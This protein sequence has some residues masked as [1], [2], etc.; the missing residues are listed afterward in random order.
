MFKYIKKYGFL[1][2]TGIILIQCNSIESDEIVVAEVNDKKLYASDLAEIIPNDITN[3]DS[4]L[5]A[6]DYIKKWVKQE[7]VIQKANENL[8]LE[9]KD[10]TIRD[11]D[12][13]KQ[14]RV[15]IEKLPEVLDK[16][17]NKEITFEDIE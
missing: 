15:L 4:V 8:T 6:N 7:L 11:R 9:Q 13:T 1:F 3:E 5:M 2:F 14:K 12:T 16:L 10:V 17:L